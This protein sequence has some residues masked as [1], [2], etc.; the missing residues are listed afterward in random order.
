MC[1]DVGVSG[2]AVLEGAEVNVRDRSKKELAE[3]PLDRMVE[4]VQAK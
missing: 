1:G 3:S 4:T 2:V